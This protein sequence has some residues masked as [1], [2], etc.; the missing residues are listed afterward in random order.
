[1]DFA[2]DKVVS[3]FKC[4][5]C[6]YEGKITEPFNFKKHKWIFDDTVDSGRYTPEQV[7]EIEEL[8]KQY[9]KNNS[10]NE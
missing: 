6:G 3:T 5:K 7:R 10:N 1:M 2:L 9:N 4:K 8:S